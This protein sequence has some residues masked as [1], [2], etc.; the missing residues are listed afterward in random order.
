[1]IQWSF[2]F[3]A[4]GNPRPPQRIAAS[5]PHVSQQLFASF[6]TSPRGGNGTMCRACHVNAGKWCQPANF[7]DWV[8]IFWLVVEPTHLKNMLVKLGSSSPGGEHI[9]YLKPPPRIG[10]ISMQLITDH[11]CIGL[12]SKK[13]H[14]PLYTTW[15]RHPGIICGFWGV[16]IQQQ[17][18]PESPILED[19]RRFQNLMGKLPGRQP[20]SPCD[21]QH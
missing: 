6:A 12:L 15:T 5:C 11:G 21:S 19:H 7:A 1:M 16:W 14:Q 20:F 9:K 2:G 3:A 10:Q 13:N 17:D 18:T 4:Q 8:D